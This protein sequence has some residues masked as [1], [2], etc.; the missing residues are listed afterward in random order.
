[1]IHKYAFPI[2]ILII[3]FISFL[4]ITNS[5]N[6]TNG[7]I[8]WTLSFKLSSLSTLNAFVNYIIYGAVILLLLFIYN[9]FK[10]VMRF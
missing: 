5:I 3:I 10:A 2:L 6:Y 1:M 8:N 4:I 7:S 9:S